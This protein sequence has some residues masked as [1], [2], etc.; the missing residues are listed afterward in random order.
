M[1]DDR[2]ITAH[3][4]LVYLKKELGRHRKRLDNKLEKQGGELAET[5]KALWYRQIADS[6]ASLPPSAKKGLTEEIVR[7]IHTG[8]DEI[9]PLNPTLTLRR[10]IE[11]LYKKA[12]KADRG[13]EINEKKVAETKAH[14][15][16][17]TL[18]LD[19]CEKALAGDEQEETGDLAIRI[20][21]ALEGHL[22]KDRT[23]SASRREHEEK[24]PYRHF[25]IDGWDVY[26]GKNDAQNDELTTRFAKN[27]DLWLHVAG[28]A[29]SHLVIRRPQRTV[30]VPQEVV[31]KVA[32]LAVW[33]SKAK[34]TSYAEV[35]VTEARFVHKRRHSP[36]G[37]VI[38][39]RCTTLRV[40]PLSPQEMFPGKY[41]DAE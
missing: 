20:E 19:E 36:A 3:S 28:H 11:L 41:D 17:V 26:T 15:T 32:A 5:N 10:N 23:T 29:G 38:A 30:T 16:T 12:K 8:R 22:P 6:L 39:E 33:F 25:S 2:P 24:I 4:R 1:M 18:L 34:H 13:E 7:N 37:Q 9:V 21:Q 31:L 14:I 35:H 27:N 40:S